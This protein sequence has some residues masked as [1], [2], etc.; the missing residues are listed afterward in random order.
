MLNTER[1]LPCLS[2]E[3]GNVVLRLKIHRQET[4]PFDF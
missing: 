3:F 4:E 1:T 2:A